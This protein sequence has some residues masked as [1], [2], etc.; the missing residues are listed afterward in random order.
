MRKL[1]YF[2]AACV[3]CAGAAAVAGPPL[4][5]NVAPQFFIARAAANTMQ[6]FE[7]LIE[8]VQT[9]V[10]L[11]QNEP[12]RNELT[13]GVSRVEGN[14]ADL[15]PPALH[16]ALPMLSLRNVIRWDAPRENYSTQH[17]LQLAATTVISA[18]LHLE[19]DQI[20]VG[21]P[22]LFDYSLVLDPRR[23][24]SEINEYLLSLLGDIWIVLGNDE[25]FYRYYT[26]FLFEA[27]EEWEEIDIAEYQES[28]TE[29]LSRVDF[30]YLGTEDGQEVYLA[31]VP[32]DGLEA[33]VY[34]E[35]NRLV[36]VRF[37]GGQV[38]FPEPGRIE[39][40]MA[41]VGSGHLSYANQGVSFNVERPMGYPASVEGNV[42]LFSSNQEA[43]RIEAE[44][45]R[46]VINIPGSYFTLNAR[47]L[48][49]SDPEPVLFEP[50]HAR[51]PADLNIFDLLAIYARIG[52]TPLGALFP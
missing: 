22:A 9:L 15:I 24:I 32:E 42:R 27:W 52:N 6:E 29:L 36:R 21:V 20:A 28:I 37:D 11:V 23:I 49:F 3:A 18:D 19:R 16:P 31:A 40:E 8:A 4:A 10:P 5:R 2:L 39:F 14:A 46:I 35:G 17:H 26:R 7:P 30:E 50:I 34:L 13:M 33:T 45:N 12:L 43:W 47:L 48:T 41:H 25:M 1:Y 44:L 51:R 38:S